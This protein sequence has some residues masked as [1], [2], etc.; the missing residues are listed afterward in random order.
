MNKSKDLHY[1]FAIVKFDGT[2]FV[3][4]A[5]DYEFDPEKEIIVLYNN[6]GGKVTTYAFP[7]KIK[8]IDIYDASDLAE[9]QTPIQTILGRKS[10]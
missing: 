6:Y 2:S 5:D 7:N 4:W 10:A 1:L 9:N 8:R 3:I